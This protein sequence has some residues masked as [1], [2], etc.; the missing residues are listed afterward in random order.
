[1]KT[2]DAS[3]IPSC[4][5]ESADAFLFPAGGRDIHDYVRIA[6]GVES[7]LNLA[8]TDPTEAMFEINRSHVFMIRLKET[9]RSV[10]YISYEIKEAGHDYISE[11]A[12]EP[13]HQG[14][15]IGDRAFGTLLEHLRQRDFLTFTLVTHPDNPARRLY[16]RHGF[17]FDGKIENYEESGTPRVVLKR[18][19]SA[20]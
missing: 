7:P 16:E 4:G 17:A 20:G 18:Q 3:F 19:Y 5:M 1:M 6:R 8:I 14:K 2:P 9:R 10:G 15:G 13:H 11:L 12:V